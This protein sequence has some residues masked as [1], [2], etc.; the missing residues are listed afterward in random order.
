LPELIVCGEFQFIGDKLQQH[1]ETEI[2]KKSDPDFPVNQQ[3]HLERFIR[4]K[5][6]QHQHLESTS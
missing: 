1:Q 5:K 4:N 6:T 2:W 3:L